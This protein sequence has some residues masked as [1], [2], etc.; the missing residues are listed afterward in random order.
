MPRLTEELARLNQNI[1]ALV[2]ELRRHR[3]ASDR[4]E[5]QPA[6]VPEDQR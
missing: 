6:R 3:P 4:R 2:I 1:E 5:P